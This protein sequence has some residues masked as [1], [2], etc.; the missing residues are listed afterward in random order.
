MRTVSII[1]GTAIL[2]M[3]VT[4]TINHYRIYSIGNSEREIQSYLNSRYEEKGVSPLLLELYPVENSDTM[5]ATYLHREEK[6]GII[7]L[8]KGFNQSF[9]VVKM[10]DTKPFYMEKIDT[11]KGSFTLFAGE[12]LH[13]AIKTISFDL[14]ESKERKSIKIPPHKY[15]THIEKVE[16]HSIDTLSATFHYRTLRGA[17]DSL[18]P[19]HIEMEIMFIDE[20]NQTFLLHSL[21]EQRLQT[22]LGSFEHTNEGYLVNTI[23][24]PDTYSMT[25]GKTFCFEEKKL[26]TSE[27][28]LVYLHGLIPDMEAVNK[29]ILEVVLEDEMIYQAASEVKNQQFLLNV[30]IPEEILLGGKVKKKFH[31]YDKAGRY[32]GTEGKL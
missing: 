17:I 13:L 22:V 19:G 31:L 24:E 12:N 29:V 18:K 9:K 8:K 16:T 21:I 5:V 15:F 26:I 11:N 27:K 10:L 3:L 25:D 6:M 7:I 1:I 14:L 32:L 4:L 23:L 20:Y 2:L 28:E 30:Q